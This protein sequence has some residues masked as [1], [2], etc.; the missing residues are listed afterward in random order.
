M[1]QERHRISFLSPYRSY[2]RLGSEFYNW[3]L[4]AKDDVFVGAVVTVVAAVAR[5]RARNALAIAALELVAR[6]RMFADV[7]TERR[8]VTHVAAIVVSVAV[9]QLIAQQPREKRHTE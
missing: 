9:E 3:A 4:T 7:R 1:F 5:F 8:L 6:A 2:D